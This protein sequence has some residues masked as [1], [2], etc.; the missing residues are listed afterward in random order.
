VILRSTIRPGAVHLS[1]PLH[2]GDVDDAERILLYPTAQ[3]ELSSIRA[4]AFAPCSYIEAVTGSGA[5]ATV[6]TRSS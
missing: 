1:L 2:V 5:T 3:R 6:S 4:S